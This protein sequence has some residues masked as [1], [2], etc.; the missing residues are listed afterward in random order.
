MASSG[1]RDRHLDHLAVFGRCRTGPRDVRPVHGERGDGGEQG[2]VKLSPDEVAVT[3]LALTEIHEAVG[4]PTELRAQ[5]AYQSVGLALLDHRGEVGK[6]GS[7]LEAGAQDVVA[8]G[9]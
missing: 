9:V 3:G 4:Q 7:L 1:A 6:P 8:I 5:L 2:V